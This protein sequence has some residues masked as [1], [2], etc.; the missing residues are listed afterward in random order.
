VTHFG[1]L[2]NGLKSNFAAAGLPPDC[3]DTRL[4]SNL[5]SLPYLVILTDTAAAVGA[6]AVGTA[7]AAAAAGTQKATKLQDRDVG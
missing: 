7:A 1:P 6:A 5:N 4:R 2:W 3:G